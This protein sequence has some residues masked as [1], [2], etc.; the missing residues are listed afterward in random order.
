MY[1]CM[2]MHVC[3]CISLHSSLKKRNPFQLNDFRKFI[4]KE[5]SKYLPNACTKTNLSNWN[6]R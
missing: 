5:H 6:I 1:I 3:I 2:H 4:R